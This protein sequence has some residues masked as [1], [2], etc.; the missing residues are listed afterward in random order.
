MMEVANNTAG[1]VV[2]SPTTQN[3]PPARFT[4]DLKDDLATPTVKVID[5]TQSL[6]TNATSPLAAPRPQV[7]LQE[8]V[9]LSVALKSGVPLDVGDHDTEAHGN[10]K[11]N[12]GFFEDGVLQAME[13]DRTARGNQREVKVISNGHD[14]CKCCYLRSSATARLK[15]SLHS[16]G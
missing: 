16:N 15:I 3:G 12:D 7:S 4:A 6:T 13:S 1:A 9:A 8:M 10:S 5:L 11:H 2:Q 14:H